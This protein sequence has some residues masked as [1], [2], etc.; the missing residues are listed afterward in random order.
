MRIIYLGP[1]RLPNK[2]AAAARVLNVARALR[3]AGH[4]VS[5]I[6]WGGVERDQDRGEDGICR[7]DGFPYFVTNEIDIPGGLILKV[8][9]RL[10]K[11]NKTKKFLKERKGSYDAI[12]TYG[13]GLA[14]GLL[15]FCRKHKLYLIGDFTEWYSY[16]EMTIIER[17]FYYYDTHH[18]FPKIKNKILI[19]SFLD[20]SYNQSH[21]IVVPATCDLSEK[22]WHTGSEAALKKAGAYDGITLLYAGTPDQKDAVHY[23]I[24]AVNRLAAEGKRI[25]FLVLGCEREG[26]INRFQGL[27]SQRELS[28]NIRFLGRVSQ[29]EVPSYYALSDFMVLLRE[30]TRKSNAGFPT[31]FSESFTSGTP[32][33]ANITSDL[34]RY[35]KD[36]VTGI[37]VPEPSEDA[38]YKTLN[39]KVL[40][41][42]RDTINIMKQNVKDAAVQLDYHSY[43]EPLRAFMEGL[44]K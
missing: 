9:G 10:N 30:Q 20:R 4:E 24:G 33:I 28:D 42:L 15:R 29:D 3:L 19:S 31:K 16:N 40:T 21:N 17:P 18:L 37:V 14:Y 8:I 32:V 38:I 41:L 11:G 12:I 43:V 5:F 26:Y 25:R 7:V 39:E 1:F 23:V 44:K 34:G 22:K 2:D 27:L 13:G 36:G 6:S 35:L